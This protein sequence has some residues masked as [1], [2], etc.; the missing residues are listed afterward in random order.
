MPFIQE[1]FNWEKLS[2]IGGLTL[3]RFCFRLHEGSIRG[4]QVAAFLREMLRP[5]PGKLVVIWDGAAMH[6]SEPVKE[7]RREGRRSAD[8]SPYRGKAAARWSE[9]KSKHPPT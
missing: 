8:R 9:L 6:R 1:T 5:L 7:V 2:L 4:P 3:Q